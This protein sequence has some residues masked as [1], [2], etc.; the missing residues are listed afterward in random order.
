M[1]IGDV[2][3][4]LSHSLTHTHTHT[5]MYNLCIPTGYKQRWF[6]LKGNLL[7]YY[8]L[9]EYGGWQVR[10]SAYKGSIVSVV[11]GSVGNY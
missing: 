3:V 8:K 2:N 11:G 10:T 5:H 1:A 4:S 9:D 6:R 7:F